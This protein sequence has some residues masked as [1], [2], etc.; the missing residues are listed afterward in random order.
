MITLPPFLKPGDTIGITCPAGFM[1][2]EKAARCIETLRAWKYNVAVG[3]TLGSGSQNYF[4]GTDEERLNELQVMLDDKNISAILF[5]RGGYGTGRIIDQLNFKKFRKNPKWLIGFS[6]ITVLH[7]HLLSKYKVASIHGPMAALFND[8]EA[9]VSIESL[10]TLLSGKK[11]QFTL[12]SNSK[13]ITGKA[14][15]MLVGG[16]LALLCNII[17]TPSDFKTDNRILFIED[18]GEYIYS[19]DR[20]FSQLHRSGKFKNLAGLILG[21]FS[22]MKDTER[23]FGKTVDEVL[24]EWA[25]KAGCPV[26]FDFPVSHGANNL[27]LITGGKYQL[28]I[29]G[30]K[31]V[32]KMV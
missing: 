3:L 12:P 27:A 11:Q 24:Y 30:E 19:V 8:E 2:A 26:A 16:N 32:L 7:N 5:G 10:R 22:D 29:S 9:S 18:I 17:G 21:G 31:T 4:S 1:P 13:N 20:M 25:L 6:D 15:G 23:P 14:T 28:K